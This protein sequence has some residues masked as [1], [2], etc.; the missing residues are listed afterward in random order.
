MYGYFKESF[1]RLNPD[2]DGVH[3]KLGT[4]RTIE[5]KYQSG[6]SRNDAPENDSRRIE[7]DRREEV[8]KSKHQ[9]LEYAQVYSRQDGQQT[10]FFIIWASIDMAADI[11][12]G[13]SDNPRQLDEVKSLQAKQVF[14]GQMS[15]QLAAVQLQQAAKADWGDLNNKIIAD[16]IAYL[17]AKQLSGFVRFDDIVI[18]D[19]PVNPDDYFALIEPPKYSITWTSWYGRREACTD[20]ILDNHPNKSSSVSVFSTRPRLCMLCFRPKVVIMVSIRCLRVWV[21]S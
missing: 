9:L 20:S 7:Q 19:T 8:E 10:A 18:A 11:I 17:E 16:L 14:L 2:T 13:I 1:F 21:A 4:G 3:I 15:W 6:I 5:V 12:N